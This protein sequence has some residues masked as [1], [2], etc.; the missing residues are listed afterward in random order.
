[1]KTLIR[2]LNTL[3][4][5]LVLSLPIANSA[6]IASSAKETMALLDSQ[7]NFPKQNKYPFRACH[8]QDKTPYPG[9][10]KFI[11]A[12]IDLIYYSNADIFKRQNI[13]RS[14]LCAGVIDS[15]VDNAF[16]FN[17][18]E[19]Q[20]Q[21]FF[22][23]ATILETGD[24]FSSL[25]SIVAHEL[26][27]IL[28]DAPNYHYIDHLPADLQSLWRKYENTKSQYLN[29]EKKVSKEVDRLI[30]N[31]QFRSRTLFMRLRENDAFQSW[32]YPDA[33]GTTLEIEKLSR[34]EKLDLDLDRK[35]GVFKEYNSLAADYRKS[36]GEHYQS[37][38]DLSEKYNEQYGENSFEAFDEIEADLLGSFIY[39]R[40]GLSL[41]DT[42]TNVEK[43]FLFSNGVRCET[44]VSQQLPK[45][46]PMNDG[47]HPTGCFRNQLIH[48]FQN[49]N[50]LYFG[51]FQRTAY[52]Q[53]LLDYG[54][55]VFRLVKKEIRR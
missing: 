18:E 37:Q 51:Q 46:I 48:Q 8:Q 36:L 35:A 49:K 12:A 39:R 30:E 14:D 44:S 6:A 42:F 9:A 34:K 55:N 33:T 5:I 41:N 53:S 23:T 43:R 15:S 24:N 16:V 29:S 54:K 19:K 25:V 38:N 26:G 28:L 20:G 2:T 47:A 3:F 40:A 17:N 50:S 1:M 13:Q 4:Y 32:Q 21:I 45:D 10:K 7:F 11:E 31:P 52:T 27:H 22:H